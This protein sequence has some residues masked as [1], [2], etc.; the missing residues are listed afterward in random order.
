M[1]GMTFKFQNNSQFS[2]RGFGFVEFNTKEARENAL[3]EKGNSFNFGGR[4]VFLHPAY[5]QAPTT[6][7]TKV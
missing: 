4:N 2:S 5:E 6:E 3:N 7:E 1:V